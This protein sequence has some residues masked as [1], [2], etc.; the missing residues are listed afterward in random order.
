[1]NFDPEKNPRIDSGTSGQDY[2][3][4]EINDNNKD[5]TRDEIVEPKDNRAPYDQD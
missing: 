5:G 3:R 1:M 4:V 2:E